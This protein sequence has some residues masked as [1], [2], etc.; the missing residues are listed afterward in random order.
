MGIP[1]MHF[2]VAAHA[3]TQLTVTGPTARYVLR[4]C[5]GFTG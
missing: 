1:N 3:E 2:E 5:D 4:L